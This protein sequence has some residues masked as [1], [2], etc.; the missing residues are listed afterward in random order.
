MPKF[1]KPV[2]NIDNYLF[3]TYHS[4]DF[5][6]IHRYRAVFADG[7]EC[8]IQASE[9]HACHPRKTF[10][11]PYDEIQLGYLSKKDPL[12]SEYARDPEREPKTLYEYVPDY[13]V[14]KFIAKHGGIIATK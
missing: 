14:N 5:D 13:I 8:S 11:G 9:Q 6:G 2:Y 7:F 1:D 4:D 3:L 10:E 12:L